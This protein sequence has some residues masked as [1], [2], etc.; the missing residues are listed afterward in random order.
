MIPFTSLKWTLQLNQNL[1]KFTVKTRHRMTAWS[2]FMT[3][4]SACGE[5]EWKHNSMIWRFPV[6]QQFYITP[7]FKL[8]IKNSKMYNKTLMLTQSDIMIAHTT[9][10]KNIK[11]PNIYHISLQLVFFPLTRHFLLETRHK[12]GGCNWIKH[13]ILTSLTFEGVL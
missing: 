7:L 1:V 3:A 4:Q 9:F 6:L 13:F 5:Q 10:P 2:F 12:I 11:T 8:G